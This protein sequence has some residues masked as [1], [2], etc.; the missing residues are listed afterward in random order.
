MRNNP[1]VP[2]AE[3]FRKDK[4]FEQPATP[5]PDGCGRSSNGCRPISELEFE[6]GGE[7]SFTLG[8]EN[9]VKIKVAANGDLALKFS[10]GHVTVAV[11]VT[12]SGKT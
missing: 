5:A 10:T 9:G 2:S 4:P 6:I 3:G 11:P 7:A 12:K 1:G 8:C